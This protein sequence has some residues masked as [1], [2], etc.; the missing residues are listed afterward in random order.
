MERAGPLDQAAPGPPSFQVAAMVGGPGV[1]GGVDGP[2]QPSST[3]QPAVAAHLVA[4]PGV[5]VDLWSQPGPVAARAAR[6]GLD[7]VVLRLDWA[8]FEP[9]RG[10]FD[11][12]AF[13]RA[14]QVVESFAAAGLGVHLVLG[15]GELPAWAGP[16][17]WLFP[18]AP[19]HFAR[20]GAEVVRHLGEL[21]GGIVTMEAPAEWALAGWV[22]GVA[23]PFRSAAPLDALAALDG[24]LSAHVLATEAIA[25]ID[26][27]RDCSL[28]GSAGLL[29]ALEATLLDPEGT[30]LE[31]RVAGLIAEQAPGRA[32]RLASSTSST[33]ARAQWAVFGAGPSPLGR[34][35][36]SLLTSPGRLDAHE[37]VE[38]AERPTGTVHLALRSVVAHEDADGSRSGQAEPA[39]C[40]DLGALL[41]GARRVE[42]VGTRLGLVVVGE[43][44]DRWRWG[45]TAW[46]EGLIGVD[47]HRG[48]LGF[49]LE[50]A[51]AQLAEVLRSVRR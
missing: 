24:L 10:S 13:A 47:R 50:A 32:R 43:L 33:P 44:V 37:V 20:F 15:G 45:S 26:P 16:E 4:D 9:T 17:A 40:A 12:A 8:R 41:E 3:W 30:S 14:A 51:D 23:P 49:R 35:L 18:A 21:V 46:R 2:G 48:D 22:S 25:A 19:E 31:P 39:R 11:P 27:T 36:G 38:S 42:A 34:R 28:L 6:L 29:G 5:G 1:S 7:A